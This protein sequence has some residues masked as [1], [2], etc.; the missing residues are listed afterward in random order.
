M[1]SQKDTSSFAG[2]T[3]FDW[4]DFV[5]FYTENGVAALPTNAFTRFNFFEAYIN[6]QNIPREFTRITP[7][8]ILQN[9]DVITNASASIGRKYICSFIFDIFS[10][11]L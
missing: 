2:G 8:L 9:W 3:V 5:T 4:K 6:D 1:I 11:F 7:D 10:F